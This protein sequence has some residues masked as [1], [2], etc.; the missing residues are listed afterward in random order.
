MLAVAAEY[1]NCFSA[2]GKI[3][4]PMSALDMTL[5]SLMMRLQ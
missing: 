5:N 3:P 4:H 1:T 2:K